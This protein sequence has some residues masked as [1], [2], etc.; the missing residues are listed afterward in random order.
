GASH[1]RVRTEDIA[2]LGQLYLQEG[3]WGTKQIL[4][5]EWVTMA[6]K[7]EIGNGKNDN[8]WAFGYGYQFWMNPTGGFRADGAYGQYSIVLP[9]K[10]TV[11]AITSE[12]V[13]K[14]ATM[15]TVWDHLYPGIKEMTP[16]P[17]NA[18]EH[19]QLEKEL[20]ALAFKP[21]F[22][23]SR[24]S[25]AA[26]ISGKK[27]ILDSNPFNAKAV[28]FSF[29]SGRTVF[30][31]IEDGKPDIVITCGMKDWII[32]GNK[33]PSAQSLFSLRRIDFDSV[34]AAS[35]TWKD[36]HILLLTFRF[37]ETAHGDSLTCIF[38]G[39]KLRIQFLFSAARLEH[40]PDDRADIIGKMES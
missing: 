14:A 2:R 4:S 39:D 27:F 34:V 13:D 12:S 40:T 32:H 36:E 11:V 26:A 37:M 38:E 30:R 3:R 29:S 20:K 10:D 16:L 7:K 25:F 8:S 22:I 35:A 28:S 23:K 19:V 33:K 24:S 17:S 5:E 21:P 1:L 18:A 31:L 9:D 15:A 6:T